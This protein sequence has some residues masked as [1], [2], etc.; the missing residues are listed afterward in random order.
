M[1]R[2]TAVVAA[3]LLLACGARDHGADGTEGGTSSGGGSTGTTATA[4]DGSSSTQ[5][6][7]SSSGADESSTGEPIVPIDCTESCVDTRSDAGIMLCYSCRCK[8]AFDNWLPTRDEVQCSTATDIVTYHADVSG[9]D[10][11]LEPAAD[12]ATACTN[13]S[14]LTGSCR[15]GSKLGQLQHGDVMLRWIC[16]DPYEDVDGTVIYEDMGLIGQN[17]RTGVA[18]FWDDIDDVTHDDDMPP[19]DLMEASEAEREHFLE[20]FYFVD[21]SGT[22][23]T[24]H[25]HDPFIF[26]PYLQS[27]QWISV[28]A[29]KGPYSFARL[30]GNAMP[31]G[32]SHLVSRE[33]AACTAC[34]RIG[35]EGT[36]SSFAPNSLGLGKDATH[37][38]S[39]H[40]AA[41]PGD[42]HW[43][44]AYWMPGPGLAVPDFDAW[45]MLFGP[46][47][48]H[49]LQCCA[50]P[51]VDAG[52]CLWEPVPAQR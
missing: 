17:T 50:A 4:G 15:Q 45:Q 41:M 1:P 24:C 40:D 46:A 48:D 30:D 32:N 8:A 7:S 38:Q 9:A 25:D 2:S 42:P 52:G 28:A 44:L 33:A 37:E 43:R 18:C 49:V 47:R 6:S 34:H 35:S 20:V 26:T 10:T 21:G 13:P 14:L 19:L 23:R 51:G 27:T 11:V 29:D 5:A 39:V 22:C 12:D 36:C 31:T 3:L 16:R